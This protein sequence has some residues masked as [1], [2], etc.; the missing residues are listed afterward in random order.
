V[1]ANEA[2]TPNTP[3]FS[4]QYKLILSGVEWDWWYCIWLIHV[5]ANEAETPNTPLFLLSIHILI[6]SG[7]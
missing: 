3:L 6:L 5:L 2:E 4:S 7:G 1:V